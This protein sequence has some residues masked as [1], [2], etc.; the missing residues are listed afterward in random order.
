MFII[1]SYLVYENP[2]WPKTDPGQKCIAIYTIIILFMQTLIFAE[3]SPLLCHA[4]Y[5]RLLMT[6]TAMLRTSELD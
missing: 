2:A 6:I 1:L 5:H 3:H 4:L